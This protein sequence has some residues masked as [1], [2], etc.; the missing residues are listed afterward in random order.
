MAFDYLRVT[1]LRGSLLLLLPAMHV[2]NAFSLFTSA[3]KET[4]HGA[5]KTHFFQSLPQCL[6]ASVKPHCDIVQRRAE[7]CGYS[8]SRFAQDIGAPDDISIVCLESRQQLIEAVTYH[9]VDLRVGCDCLTR[10]FEILLFHQNLPAPMPDRA[11]L[12]I[13]DCRRQD[14]AKPSPD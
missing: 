10:E 9:P 12:V 11:A 2:P 1:G 8:L 13:G 5:S 3:V 4:V 6:A 14:P 7:A